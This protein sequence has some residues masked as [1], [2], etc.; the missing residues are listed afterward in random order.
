MARPQR[1]RNSKRE[2]ADLTR[3]DDTSPTRIA[4]FLADWRYIVA[5]ADGGRI[6]KRLIKIDVYNTCRRNDRAL[7]ARIG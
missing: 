2:F 1:E 4:K 6:G 5:A 7:V 3:S